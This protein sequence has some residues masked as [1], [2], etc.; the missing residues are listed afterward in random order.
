M[1]YTFTC[2]DGMHLVLT[3]DQMRRPET[4]LADH[5]V[6]KMGDHEIGVVSMSDFHCRI[7]ICRPGEFGA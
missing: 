5:A 1:K 7:L 3:P 4:V 6:P 2:K